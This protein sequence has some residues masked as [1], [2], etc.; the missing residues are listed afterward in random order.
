MAKMFY[1]LEEAA[2]RLK[3]STD[4][5]RGMANKGQI[6]EFRDGDRLL[7]KVDQIDLLAGDEEHDISEMSSMIPLADTGSN[8][9]ALGLAD[10]SAPPMTT[11]SGS[12]SGEAEA[13]EKSGIPVFDADE[14]EMADPS[15][16]T[17]VTESALDA[18]IEGGLRVESLGS[19]SG[20]M[21]IT[22]ES[23]DTSLGA[24]GLLD[25]MYP[26]QE[27]AGASTNAGTGL[28]E[29]APSAGAITT[30][31][32]AVVAYAAEP[33]DGPGSG[34]TGG[35]ALG[36]VLAAGFAVAVIIMSRVGFIPTFL[37]QIGAENAPLIWL[38][39][40]AGASVLFAGLGFVLARKT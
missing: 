25:E 11:K 35:L 33:Y 3:K 4:E 38:G 7:F 16:V 10:S 36:A 37:T 13:K 5:V 20:L 22:R 29:G 28:F 26:A 21:D 1:S 18:G 19:G 27:E 17:Q 34:L 24:A 9:S 39:I 31:A 32:A 2:K 12:G 23:D 6:T 15:A 14:L 30:G 8:M 40:F